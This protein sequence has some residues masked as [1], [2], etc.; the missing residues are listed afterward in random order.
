MTN[1][2]INAQALYDWVEKA[3]P[4]EK[5]IYAV[6]D[7]C[8]SPREID[9]SVL[10]TIRRAAQLHLNGEV[11]LLQRRVGPKPSNGLVGRFEYLAVKRREIT[12]QRNIWHKAEEAWAC[13]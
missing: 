2:G 1:T 5:L 11:E 9:T 3:Q 12:P 8:V 6:L 10:E 13:A 4:G 7:G